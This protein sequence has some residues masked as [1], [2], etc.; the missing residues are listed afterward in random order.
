M[1][2]SATSSHSSSSSEAPEGTT[3]SAPAPVR[4][5]KEGADE[6]TRKAKNISVALA[7]GCKEAIEAAISYP[8]TKECKKD[9]ERVFIKVDALD[10]DDLRAR[11]AANPE[12]VAR[13]NALKIDGILEAMHLH[14][15]EFLFDIF[16]AIEITNPPFVVVRIELAGRSSGRT[17]S[18]DINKF[19]KAIQVWQKAEL[20]ASATRC[21]LGALAVVATVLIFK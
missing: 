5:R 4:T 2:A 18:I 12:I 10:F 15:E 11:L 13:R 9:I 14:A 3:P 16:D 7:R 19:A 17:V 1:S 20:F 21:V 6:A 8:Y